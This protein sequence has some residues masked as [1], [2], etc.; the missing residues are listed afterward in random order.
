MWE[1]RKEES[2]K[3]FLAFCPKVK[4]LFPEAEEV[5]PLKRLKNN[6]LKFNC[7]ERRVAECEPIDL[8]YGGSFPVA[9]SSENQL[10]IGLIAAHVYLGHLHYLSSDLYMFICKRSAQFSGIYS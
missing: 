10:V 4:S 8:S 3:V 9:G 7:L 1:E 5:L 6:T 2:P